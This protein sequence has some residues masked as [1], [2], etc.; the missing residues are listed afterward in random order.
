MC[1]HEVRFNMA[2]RAAGFFM[3]LVF[4]GLALTG[5]AADKPNIVLIMVDDMGYKPSMP[6]EAGVSRFVD[7]YSDYYGIDLKR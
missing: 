5:I 6:V 3:T 1:G 4:A 7:W 2:N